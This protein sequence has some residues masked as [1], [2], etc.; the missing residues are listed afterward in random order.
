MTAHTH[1]AQVAGDTPGPKEQ[2]GPTAVGRAMMR[3]RRDGTTG[4]LGP[5]DHDPR[6]TG[7][8]QTNRVGPQDHTW[9]V[10]G[11]VP[12]EGSEKRRRWGPI[13]N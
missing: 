4:K 7:P 10:A 5:Q 9:W 6:R 1:Q 12:D 3:R 11:P 8:E 13:W 2:A